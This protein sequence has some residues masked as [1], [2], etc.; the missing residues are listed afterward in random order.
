[1]K[2]TGEVMAIGT[3]FEQAIMK[4]VRGAEISSPTST[5]P[6]SRNEPRGASFR[7]PQDD[8]RAPLC[9]LRRFEGG[10]H[11]RRNFGITKID[12]WFLHKLLNLVKFERSVTGKQLSKEEY[13][14]GKRLGYPDR[15]SKV[16]AGRRSHA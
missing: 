11:P 8:G 7:A 5:T 1:M 13:L 12:R 14:E 4:A 10:H 9:G 6:S 3:S 15:C 16:T 2:A